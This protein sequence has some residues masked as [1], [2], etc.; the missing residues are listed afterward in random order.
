MTALRAERFS[1][2]F[3]VARLSAT[4]LVTSASAALRV[5]RPCA[6]EAV[7]AAR[8]SA[9][10][11]LR[12]ERFSASLAVARLSATSAVRAEI[13]SVSAVF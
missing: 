11:A 5:A 3:A 9:M 1:A 13:V 2:S 4:W 7:C 6:S 12:A 10:T 8:P